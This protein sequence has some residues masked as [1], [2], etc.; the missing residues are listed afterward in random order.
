MVLNI[1]TL[2]GFSPDW[3]THCCLGFLGVITW[4]H[5]MWRE[6]LLRVGGSLESFCL[7][8]TTHESLWK[9]HCHHHAYQIGPH[10]YIGP[11]QWVQV[12]WELGV[13]E[14]QDYGE[15]RQHM[16]SSQLKRV[17]KDK[18]SINEHQVEYVCWIV[19][20]LSSPC[21]CLF[22]IL[23]SN[24]HRHSLPGP[25]T[26]PYRLPWPDKHWRWPLAQAWSVIGSQWLAIARSEAGP[27]AAAMAGLLLVLAW[28]KEATTWPV[29]TSPY[30]CL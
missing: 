15:N 2:T 1:L 12:G 25:L 19:I 4:D 7:S 30:L 3:R 10:A 26:D 11:G 27:S 20:C 8:V 24:P 21:H 18:Q 9:H 6:K 29:P 14:A 23:W 28:H 16:E 5:G 17:N 13:T 22:T